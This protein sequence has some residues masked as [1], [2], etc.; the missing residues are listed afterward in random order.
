MAAGDTYFLVDR[1][2][3]EDFYGDPQSFGEQADLKPTLICFCNF[4][5]GRSSVRLGKVHLISS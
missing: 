4:P 2:R 3:S 1:H 5:S